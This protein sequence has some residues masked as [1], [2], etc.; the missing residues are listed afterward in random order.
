MLRRAVS[1]AA[2]R[3]QAG[4]LVLRPQAGAAVRCLSAPPQNPPPPPSPEELQKMVEMSEEKV[5]RIREGT[6]HTGREGAAG[7]VYDS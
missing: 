2:A 7:L 6:Y 1:T 3:P 5:A 4:R